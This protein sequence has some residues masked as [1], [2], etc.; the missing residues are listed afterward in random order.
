MGAADV[1]V[2]RFTLAWSAVEPSPG[3]FDWSAYDTF[4]GEA[5]LDHIRT[6]PVLVGSPTFAATQPGF[7]PATGAARAAFAAFV[8]DA[9]AR[10]GGQGSFWKS[11]PGL[12]VLP[13][14]GWQVWNE[15][16]IGSYWNN[17][18]DPAG[19]VRLLKLASRAI[20]SAD[21]RAKVVLAGF[22]NTQQ[23]SIPKFLGALYRIAGF[24]RLFDVA[25]IHTYS[26]DQHGVLADARAARS[27]MLAHHDGDKQLWITE[28]GWG[29][30]GPPSPFTT[31]LAGQSR[32]V[33]DT[34][35][36]LTRHRSELNLG[37]VVWFQWRDQPLAPGEGDWWEPH[38]GLFTLDGTPKPAWRVFVG[39]TGGSVGEG[40]VH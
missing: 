23:Y 18:P 33:R 4:I 32:L 1:R 40:S 8:H 38:T 25:A 13:P 2:F 24:S 26:Y 21:P 28:V 11:H 5:A 27:V 17:H 35:S 34:L 10:Y 15:P 6:L 29:T 9:V 19:Y 36:L 16:T 30:A 12:P 7:P 14:I 3:A 37:L 31:T 22:P 39:F 20:R